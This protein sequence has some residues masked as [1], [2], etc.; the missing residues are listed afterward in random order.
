MT[1][2]LLLTSDLPV[3]TAVDTVKCAL[4]IMDEYKV[5][6]LPLVVED[7]FK[8]LIKE[9]DLLEC[10][11]RA[12]LAEVDI[13]PYFTDPNLHVYEVVSQM[14]SFDVDVLPVVHR[15]IYRGS[16]DRGAVLKFFAQVA[17]WGAEGSTIVI[18]MPPSK[19]SLNELTRIVEENGAQI[20]SLNTIHEDNGEMVVTVKLNTIDIGSIL[21]TLKRFDY[22]VATFF[23]A[24]EV[25]DELRNKFDQFMH[26]LGQ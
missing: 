23:D 3:L 13:H 26:Y 21:A 25:E 19:Y 14:A 6:H 11:E 4:N 7:Q 9:E 20:S 15:G 16:I 5:A 12:V 22:K 10:D 8:G 2:E 1:A 17:G 18:E 24:P